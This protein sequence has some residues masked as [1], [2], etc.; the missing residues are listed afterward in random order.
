VL[1]RDIMTADLD[2]IHAI[3]EA[4]APGVHPEPPEQLAAITRESCIALAVEIE[5]AVAAFCQV[6]PPGAKYRSVNYAWF[7]QRYDDFIYLDRVAVAAEHRGRGIGSRLYEEVERRT[8]A[9]WFLLEVN[10]RPKNDGSLR[11]HARKG[12]VEVGQ[13]ETD[14]GTLVG[15]MARR[16]R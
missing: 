4:A 9:S 11:F 3:N 8:R 13:Q 6:L 10:L 1:I 15:M 5:G 16:L 12:F 7:S 14:Y 2:A